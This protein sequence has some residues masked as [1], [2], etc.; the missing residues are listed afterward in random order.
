VVDRGISAG[1][2]LRER[3]Y[4]HP[5]NIPSRSRSLEQ[6]QSHCDV[7]YLKETFHPRPVRPSFYSFPKILTPLPFVSHNSGVVSKEA[8]IVSGLVG[9][10]KDRVQME[11]DGRT[12]ATD[13][14]L[15]A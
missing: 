7:K 15:L 5:Q 2:I 6:S 4:S 13:S 3:R 14:E 8:T 1:H 10:A 12:G 9:E 11:L